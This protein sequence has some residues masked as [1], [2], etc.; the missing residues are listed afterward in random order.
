MAEAAIE[1]LAEGAVEG[2]ARGAAEAAGAAG[3]K[4]GGFRSFIS[5]A[6]NFA[7]RS[8]SSVETEVRV[9]ADAA[10]SDVARGADAA[11]TDAV[12]AATTDAT[13]GATDAAATAARDSETSAAKA[14][15]DEF[16]KNQAKMSKEISDSVANS[17]KSS[18]TSKGL[19]AGLLGAAGTLFAYYYQTEDSCKEGCQEADG[20]FVSSLKEPYRPLWDEK[21]K[22]KLE[23]QDCKDFCEST[24][25]TSDPPG[26]CSQNN[27]TQ[28]ATRQ[29]VET[30]V[31]PIAMAATAAG[32]FAESGS[33]AVGGALFSVLKGIFAA[34][35]IV[36]IV[37][38][39][40]C[41]GGIIYKVNS[42]M[43]GGGKQTGNKNIKIYFLFIFFMFIIYNERQ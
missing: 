9:A 41:C 17:A 12:A 4:K 6:K 5:A 1:V 3:A 13:R 2:T 15:E 20:K 7:S 22:D 30:G 25:E 37:F 18:M 42:V 39:I 43:S 14:A 28:R 16:M 34:N 19:K 24:D 40:I 26:V 38:V 36:G 11:T 32:A 31:T 21:C 33:S 10:A 8:G 27:R 29:T 23:S 35:P